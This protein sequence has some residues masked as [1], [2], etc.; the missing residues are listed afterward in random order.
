MKKFLFSVFILLIPA[1]SYGQFIG[2]GGQYS[3]DSNGQ[4]AANISYPFIHPKNKLNSFIASGI[5]YTTPGGS[6]ISGLNI[7]PVQLTTFFGEKFFNTTKYT[8]LMGVDGG[9]LLNFPK[10]KKNG[11]IISPNV[12]FDYKFFFIKGG[13]DFDITNGIN[14]YFVRAG[15]CIGMGTLKIFDNT[16]IR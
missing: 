5:E 15:I 8:F 3:E 2:F 14:Q 12:Y 1:L 4:F 13:Y 10:N 9:Y 6:Q 11:I 7:K 16:K